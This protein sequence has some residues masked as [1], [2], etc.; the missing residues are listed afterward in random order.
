MTF[1]YGAD[2]APAG[3]AL[4][5]LAPAIALYP[6]THLAG[7]LL[8]SQDRQVALAAVHGIVAA[9]NVAANVVLISLFSLEGAAAAASLTQLLLAVGLLAA[10]RGLARDVSWTRVLAGPLLAGALAA[11][12]MAPFRDDLGPALAVGAA[13]YVPVLV[14]FERLAFPADARALL[15]LR[16][17]AGGIESPGGSRPERAVGAR[18]GRDARR[19]AGD[20][21][22]ARG[23]GRGRPELLALRR[24][25]RRG[26]GS[27]RVRID[28]P[29]PRRPARQQ[30]GHVRRDRPG[31]GGPIRT[32]GTATSRRACSARFTA[33]GRSSRA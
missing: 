28:G 18:H 29:G 11:L 14:V 22:G 17:A 15:R 23:R 19:R 25:R 6:V 2:F 8:L 10:A 27:G 5:L 16:A 13:V 1:I 3:D 4:R 32:P 24:G 30:R 26:P 7:V 9:A 21:A 12:A 31:L 20:R 33:R